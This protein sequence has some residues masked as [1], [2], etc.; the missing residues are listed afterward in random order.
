[1]SVMLALA[2]QAGAQQIPAKRK[3][4]QSLLDVATD[5][6]HAPRKWLKHMSGDEVQFAPSPD[7]E[8][9]KIYCVLKRLD[10]IAAPVKLG[11][12]GNEQLS[13]DK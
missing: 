6:C 9:D 4:S 13:E 10:A 8:Y 7:A 2:L 12:I 1:M 5:A 3:V 11:F